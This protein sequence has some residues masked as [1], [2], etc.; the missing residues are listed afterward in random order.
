MR[1]RSKRAKEGKDLGG[2]QLSNISRAEQKRL[3]RNSLER[4]IHDKVNG[5]KRKKE[6]PNMKS[7]MENKETGS[8]SGPSV[9]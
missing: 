2:Y 7:I 9:F 6:R 1:K 4:K 3:K 8:R 5:L